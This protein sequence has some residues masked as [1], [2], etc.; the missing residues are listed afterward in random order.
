M[1]NESENKAQTLVEI[2][3]HSVIVCRAPLRLQ[4]H[5]TVC[6]GSQRMGS[7]PARQAEEKPPSGPGLHTCYEFLSWSWTHWDFWSW[8][9]S[10]A[11]GG[12]RLLLITTHNYVG[13]Q[14]T[15][16][17]QAFVFS[18]LSWSSCNFKEILRKIFPRLRSYLHEI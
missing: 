17:W 10:S 11:K 1:E 18:W 4:F 8:S 2:H 14:D 3:F 13:K 16:H 12:G 7:P 15:S 5:R 9:C 6:S